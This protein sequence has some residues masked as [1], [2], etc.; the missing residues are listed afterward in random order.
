[1]RANEALYRRAIEEVWNKGNLDDL[2]A[3]FAADYVGHDTLFPRRGLQQ[4]REVIE[5][6]RKAIT[7]IAYTV[8]EVLV[9]G[10]RIAARWTV[11]GR[12]TGELFGIQGT[13]RVLEMSGMSIN[14]VVKGRLA[15]G[16]VFNDTLSLLRQLEQQGPE[17][18]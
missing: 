2:G 8:D 18:R 10:D 4:L 1:M 14:R 3:Y 16:W 7:G 17:A 9:D 13:G 12:H 11:K 15:E 6:Y 5:R